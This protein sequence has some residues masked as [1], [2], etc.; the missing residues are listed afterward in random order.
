MVVIFSSP[1]FSL[2]HLGTLETELSKPLSTRPRLLGDTVSA[3]AA[4]DD[5]D[6]S[7]PLGSSTS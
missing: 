4:V 7:A 1:L 5:D 2:Q 3:A 6:D